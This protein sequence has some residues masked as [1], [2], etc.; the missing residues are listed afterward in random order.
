MS[1]TLLDKY[2]VTNHRKKNESGDESAGA[3]YS[4]DQIIH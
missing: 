4:P 3:V 1:N 2:N